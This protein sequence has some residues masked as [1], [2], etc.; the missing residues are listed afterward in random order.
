MNTTDAPVDP[1]LSAGSV[2]ARALR[3]P[4][5][6]VIA[7]AFLV[8]GVALA[9]ILGSRPFAG[10]N[11]IKLQAAAWVANV[12][13]LL[14]IW[15]GLRLRGQTWRRFGLRFARI[16]R[17]PAL[18][19]VLVSLGVF[20]AGLAGFAIGAIIMANIVGIPD[21]ADM[22]GY[23]YLRGNLPLTLLALVAVYIVSSFGEEVIYRGFIINRIEE[24]VGR[25]RLGTAIAVVC[26]AV[27]FGLVH[28]TWGPTGMVQTAFMGLALAVS[29]LV[30]GRNLWILILAHAYLDT[31]LIVQ[32]YL[33]SGQ[34]G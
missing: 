11:P 10:G 13:M 16:S 8:F 18:R 26:S 31:I 14:I 27:I 21:S 28:F 6:A 2:T 22:S 5:L 24:L 7:E 34:A 33:G 19:A 15:I 1:D 23:D 20:I 3:Y 29:Y 12:L 25:G 32:M 17:G 4:R 9:V 30:V